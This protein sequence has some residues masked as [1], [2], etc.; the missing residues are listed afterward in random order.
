MK[1]NNWK[2]PITIRIVA[3]ITELSDATGIPDFSHFKVHAPCEITDERSKIEQSNVPNRCSAAVRR[4]L[5]SIPKTFT[6][7]I[8]M[9]DW[10]KYY[11]SVG[12]EHAPRR[13]IDS[14]YLFRI[15]ANAD[16]LICERDLL[17]AVNNQWANSHKLQLRLTE[18]CLQTAGSNACAAIVGSDDDLMTL[19]V[20]GLNVLNSADT[21]DDDRAYQMLRIPIDDILTNDEETIRSIAQS[22][23]TE[24]RHEGDVPTPK[25]CHHLKVFLSKKELWSKPLIDYCRKLSIQTDQLCVLLLVQHLSTAVDFDLPGGT[26]RLG[27]TS[28]AALLR[29]LSEESGLKLRNLATSNHSDGHIKQSTLHV[30]KLEDTFDCYFTHLYY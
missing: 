26:R 14:I 22:Q 5:R 15:V 20:E 10:N 21:Q 1:T 25:I 29:R 19:I 7:F 28:M 18:S 24:N 4:L 17:R 27:E 2:A 6:G 23:M 8:I 16:P 3:N 13:D 12:I 9:A 30:L 11:K